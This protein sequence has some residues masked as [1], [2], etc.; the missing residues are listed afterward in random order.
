MVPQIDIVGKNIQSL[1]KVVFWFYSAGGIISRPL[2]MISKQ[3]VIDLHPKLSVVFIFL[4]PG[5][6]LRTLCLPAG[7]YADELYA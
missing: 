5:L 1:L 7:T 4:V 2:Y 6:K 3:S